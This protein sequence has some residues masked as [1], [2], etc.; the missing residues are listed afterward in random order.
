MIKEKIKQVN[1]VL[2]KKVPEFIVENYE[3]TK[4]VKYENIHKSTV[5]TSSGKEF[6]A[7]ELSQ[8]RMLRAIHVMDYNNI[9]LVKWKLA[10]NQL[11]DVDMSE[12]NEALKL[13]GELQ[14]QIWIG[15]TDA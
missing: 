4:A 10:D 2:F 13:A 9:P 6:D 14:T 11:V 5:T 3:G 12:M 1:D 8:N 15:E 7:G